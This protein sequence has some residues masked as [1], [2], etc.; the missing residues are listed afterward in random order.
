MSRTLLGSLRPA[1]VVAAVLLGLCLAP[2]ESSAARRR[3]AWSFDT[4]MLPERGV[5]LEGWLTEEAGEDPKTTLEWRLGLGLLDQ[6]EV[7]LPVEITFAGGMTQLDTYGLDARFRL[8]TADPLLA[9]KVVPL[10]R[11]GIER[12]VADDA[13]TGE[14]DFVVTG[15]VW[16][17]HA[18]ADLGVAVESLGPT[19]G[20]TYGAGAVVS[21]TDF[22]HVGAEA[23]GEAVLAAPTP[24]A[25]WLGLGPTLA[26]THGR[27]W[28]TASA[29]IGLM[30][31]APDFQGRVLWGVQF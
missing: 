5:E 10:V 12:A 25:P 8:V 13:V 26:F 24:E 6:I 27:F 28:I 31:A 19:V 11:V 15:D 16:R 4:E 21:L 30:A 20:L 3:F 18:V 14:A 2:A 7:S 29:L 1:A 23:F 22:I 17:L 9:P